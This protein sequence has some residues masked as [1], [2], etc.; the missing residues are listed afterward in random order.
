MAGLLCL[1]KCS[2]PYAPRQV[3]GM[4][5]PAGQHHTRVSGE[6]RGRSP[7]QTHGGRMLGASERRREDFETWR[8]AVN[9]ARNPFAQCCCC[10]MLSD[11]EDEA[12]SEEARVMCHTRVDGSTTFH[13]PNCLTG[14]SNYTGPANPTPA[15]P[16]LH[17]TSTLK[18]KKRRREGHRRGDNILG[19]SP[20]RRKGT[21]RSRSPTQLWKL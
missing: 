18:K 16:S 11:S 13:L 3:R 8:Q 12:V 10:D 7:R 5:A 1:R 17:P 6:R 19:A 4:K 14:R 2:A 20:S 21:V 15:N 9:P